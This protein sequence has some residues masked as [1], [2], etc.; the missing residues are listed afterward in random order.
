MSI[1]IHLHFC[2]V[3]NRRL[4]F[5]LLNPLIV[6]LL[7]PQSLLILPRCQ[8]LNIHL[9]FRVG[10]RLRAGSSAVIKSTR[11]L[12]CNFAR[13]R[14]LFCFLFPLLPAS[15]F[16]GCIFAGCG[17]GYVRFMRWGLFCQLSRW[18]D[19]V[20][21][22]RDLVVDQGASSGPGHSPSESLNHWVGLHV[23]QWLSNYRLLCLLLILYR[24]HCRN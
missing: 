6:T 1:Q 18:E 9:V 17:A 16:F 23:S 8:L 12:W 24:L 20:A 13:S 5:E 10:G 11:F 4:L 22:G 19:G 7:L 15:F 2:F 14:S 21:S 3:L